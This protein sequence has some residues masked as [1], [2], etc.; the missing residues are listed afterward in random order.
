MIT[1]EWKQCIAVFFRYAL[2]NF[3]KFGSEA[4]INFTSWFIFAF[5]NMIISLLVAWILMMLVFLGP[6][7]ITT[8][9]GYL[10]YTLQLN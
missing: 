8:R 2:Y 4:G 7:Y 5:P 6:R 1:F 9:L 3:R 10:L